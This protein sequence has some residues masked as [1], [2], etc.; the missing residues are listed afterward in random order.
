MNMLKGRPMGDSL[1]SLAWDCLEAK[2]NRKPPFASAPYQFKLGSC[3]GAPE[4]SRPCYIILE[5]QL[6]SPSGVYSF[7]RGL[8]RHL[9][10]SCTI[11]AM[12]IWPC[13]DAGALSPHG[14]CPLR[15]ALGLETIK[16]FLEAVANRE[17]AQ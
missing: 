7:I 8:I 9:L 16:I 5:G 2:R 15:V 11:L 3:H 17:S 1:Q 14:Q 6:A 12:G 10:Y 4:G 13:T